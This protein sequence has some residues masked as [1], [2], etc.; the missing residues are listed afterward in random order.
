MDLLALLTMVLLVNITA[1][2]LS[3]WIGGLGCGQPISIGVLRR[4]ILFLAVMYNAAISNSVDD[5]IT[6]LMIYAIV[7]TWSLSFVF[8][9]FCERNIWEPAL[10]QALDLLINPASACA[11]NILSLFSKEDTIL[12]ICCNIVKELLNRVLCFFGFRFFL[13]LYCTKCY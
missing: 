8:G 1:I 3:I 12:R 4:V 5:A 7:N 2:E 11:A 13:G 9:S 10:L 6:D